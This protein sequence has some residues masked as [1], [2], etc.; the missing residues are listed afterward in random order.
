M[1]FLTWKPSVVSHVTMRADYDSLQLADG[2]RVE[3]TDVMT[4]CGQCH[5][6]QMKDFNH[7][8]HGGLNGYWDLS[9]GSAAEK[10]LCGL[11]QSSY[12]AIPEDAAHIQTQRPISRTVEVRALTTDNTSPQESHDGEPLTPLLPILD[13]HSTR[14]TLLKTAGTALGLAAFGEALSPLMVIPENVSVDEFLQ[15]HYKELTD[16]DKKKVFARLEAETKERFGAT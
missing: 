6:P 13:Q 12:T 8:V 16:E 5:G 2:H 14:R 7:G 10:Q 9:R 4:L 11:P 15:Q 1:K 3:F